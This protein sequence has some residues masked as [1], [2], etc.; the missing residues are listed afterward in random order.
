MNI[1][2]FELS[3]RLFY[4]VEHKRHYV[5]CKIVHFLVP[6]LASG[7]SLS[8]AC[9]S[10]TTSEWILLKSDTEDIYQTLFNCIYCSLTNKFTFIKLGKV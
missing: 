5:V 10:S 4:E 3:V 1:N 9:D 8:V 7:A 6:L 2:I